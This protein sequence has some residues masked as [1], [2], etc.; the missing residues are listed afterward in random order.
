[1]NKNKYTFLNPPL[2]VL[3]ARML[4]FARYYVRGGREHYGVQYWPQGN[5]EKG[6]PAHDEE[7]M[8]FYVS[9]LLPGG[10]IKFL[11][12]CNS[13]ESAI[14]TFDTFWGA[15]RCHNPRVFNTKA[16]YEVNMA[17]CKKGD[18]MLYIP[19]GNVPPSL[20][21]VEEVSVCDHSGVTW[22]RCP[23]DED[24]YQRGTFK[25]AHIGQH[26]H[27]KWDAGSINTREAISWRAARS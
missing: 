8:D 4:N 3:E 13:L 19:A 21:V 6:I 27:S 12:W 2:H 11:G 10:V 5:P 9:A 7:G 23:G 22:V 16:E 20:C 25:H 24:W 1:M 14:D 26:R 18:V 17:P 15:L